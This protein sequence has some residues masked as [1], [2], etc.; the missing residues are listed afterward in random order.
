MG[1]WD[2]NTISF[3]DL[4]LEEKESDYLSK[5]YPFYL[6]YAVEG[7]VAALSDVKNWSFGFQKNFLKKHR[8]S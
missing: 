2:P 7:E 1:N 4:V 3:Q 8:S 6:A 5:P